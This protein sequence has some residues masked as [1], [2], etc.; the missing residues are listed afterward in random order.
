M[1]LIK[2]YIIHVK[3]GEIFV[4]LN[5]NQQSFVRQ[6]YYRCV[7]FRDKNSMPKKIYLFV[8][9]KKKECKKKDLRRNCK[10]LNVIYKYDLLLVLK[11]YE[12]PIK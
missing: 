12:K 10:L 2:C 6:K 4:Y 1:M 9:T 5:E 8:N 7:E 3:Q 11:R